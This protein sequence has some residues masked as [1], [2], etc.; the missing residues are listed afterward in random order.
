MPKLMIGENISEQNASLQVFAPEQN[1]SKEQIQGL[2]A[3]YAPSEL[4]L[5]TF[6]YQTPLEF[7]TSLKNHTNLMFDASKIG[8]FAYTDIFAPIPSSYFDFFRK[9][10]EDKSPEK[11]GKSKL[12]IIIDDMASAEQVRALKATGLKLT[13][14]FFP[15]DKT[16][17]KTP[18]LAREFEFFMVHLPLAALNYHYEE[19][20]TLNPSDSQELINVK[21]SQIVR[22]FH[23]VKFI[24]NHTGSLFTNDAQAMRKLFRALKAYGLVF[25]DSM[26]INTSKGALISKEFGQKPIKRDIFLDNINEV[27]A[28]KAKIKEAVNLA[29]KRGFAIAIAHP[30]TNTFK[31]LKQSK[32]LLESV[33]LVYLNELYENP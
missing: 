24:N 9:N 8:L 2:F 32:A 11:H 17:T 6:T 23:G 28:I 27:E 25:V 33:E 18:I 12:C 5:T 1:A 16:H 7:N 15:A 13:P 20:Q 10:D 21:I 31:A 14:S 30:K 3:D 26:T 22:D 19:R 4:N 29:R